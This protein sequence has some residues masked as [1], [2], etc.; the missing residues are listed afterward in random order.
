MSIAR[1]FSGGCAC[2]AI[3]Y[4]VASEPIAM[5][6]CHCRDCHR[7]SGGPFSSFVIVPTEGFKLLQG[8][9]RFHASPSEQGGM[10]RRG[11]CAE[12]GAPVVVKPDA[13]PQL[14]A[15]RTGS[16]DDASWFKPQMDVWTC[17]AHVWDQMDSAVPRF[18]RY[19]H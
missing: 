6:H 17:D 10:T 12:C 14:V 2:S 11:F 13:L 15:I 16:V 5:L 3:R 18:E 19:P 7:A 8:S 4:E 9:P 1:A